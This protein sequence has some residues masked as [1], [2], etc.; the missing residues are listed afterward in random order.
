MNQASRILARAMLDKNGDSDLFS[1]EMI[2]CRAWKKAVGKRIADH[3]SPLKLV[4]NCL[5]IEVE[6]DIW[7]SNLWGFRKQILKNL[8]K[9]IGPDIVGDVEFRVMPPRREPQ[10]ATAALQ[11]RA[12]LTDEAAGI[13]DPG[14]RRNYRR[15][16]AR[17]AGAS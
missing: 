6:D 12:D 9:C 8:E 7:R 17:A 5:V 11:L 3:T 2:A 14:L 10:R 4:R 1:R 16:R 13:E 15:A